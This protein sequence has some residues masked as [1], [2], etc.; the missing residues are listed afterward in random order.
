LT[1]GETILLKGSRG[2]ALERWIPL[3]ERDF[4]QHTAATEG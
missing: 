2:V 4:A 1:G 3:M